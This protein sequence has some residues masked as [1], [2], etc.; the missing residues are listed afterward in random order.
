MKMSTKNVWRLVL[1]GCAA[2]WLII[3]VLA[4]W[5]LM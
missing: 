5:R 2:L 3:I 1:G 4:V